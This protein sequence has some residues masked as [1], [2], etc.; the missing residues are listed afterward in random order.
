MT[1]IMT[2]DKVITLGA[3]TEA[4]L[5]HLYENAQERGE[6]KGFDDFVDYVLMRG[7]AEIERQWKSAD[8]ANESKAQAK[9]ASETYT[10]LKLK[11]K[12]G[13]TLSESEQKF[14]DLMQAALKQVR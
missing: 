13:E 9:V 5:G 12:H 1:S 11:V 8:K 6:D 4:I 14:F 7:K 3:A 2:D 10:Y